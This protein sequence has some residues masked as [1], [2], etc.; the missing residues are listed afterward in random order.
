MMPCQSFGLCFFACPV[1]K[2]FTDVE[3]CAML[4]LLAISDLGVF[5]VAKI[6]TLIS[7]K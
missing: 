7:V 5:R 1:L 4:I 6:P 2:K 3:W